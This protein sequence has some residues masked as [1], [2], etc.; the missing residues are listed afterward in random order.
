MS[1]IR[2]DPILIFA[3]SVSIFE[4]FIVLTF[5]LNPPLTY[6]NFFWRKPLAGSVFSLI[7]V[8]GIFAALFPKQCSDIF[9]FRRDDRDFASH[10]VYATSKG[11]HPNCKEFL[12]HVIQIKSHTLC[13]AC[14]GLI[15]GALMALAGTTFCFFAGWSIREMSFLAALIGVVGVIL[16]LFQLKFKGLVRLILNTFFVLGA[17]L[18]LVGIDELAQ[19]LFVD[20]FLISSIV[21][22]ISTRIMLSQ[23][24]HWRICSSCKSPC[25]AGGQRKEG[26]VSAA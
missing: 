21:F 5:V 25:E 12:A 15:L 17:F 7:C 8:L 19:S 3:I 16:G 6:E 1:S 2:H 18:I 24:D 20:L 11:H 9:H 13:A 14:T 23:W 10:T 4:I 22:W 26:S